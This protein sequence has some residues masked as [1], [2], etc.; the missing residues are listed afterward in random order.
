VNALFNQQ[1]GN[2]SAQDNAWAQ[3]PGGRLPMIRI[4]LSYIFDLASQIEPLEKLPTD[5]DV[6]WLE[7]WFDLFMAHSAIENLYVNSPYGPFIRSSATLADQLNT[8]LKKEINETDQNRTFLRWQASSIRSTYQK[9]KI[10]LQADLSILNAYF[11]TQKGGF[12]TVSLLAYGENLFPRDL[13]SKVPEAVFD[14]REAGK[15]LAYEMP[16]ACGFHVFRATE[17]VLRRYY[18]QVS[19]SKAPPKV[20]NIGVYLAAMKMQKVG[21]DKIQFSLKQLS[22]LYRNPLIHPDVVLTQ[23]EAIGVYGLA[24][25]AIGGMLAALP[26]SPPTTSTAQITAQSSSEKAVP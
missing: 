6:P 1:W 4:S 3:S 8:T 2:G 20:R 21:D 26:I 10:V 22:D 18:L 16:T 19:P 24:R 12:D 14:V 11:V 15:C 7:V 13:A 17:S 9:F 5:K 25:S 23:E